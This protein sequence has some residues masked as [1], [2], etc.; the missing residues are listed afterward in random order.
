MGKFVDAA[1]LKGK[2]ALIGWTYKKVL[3]LA[4]PVQSTL[5]T[6][7]LIQVAKYH[8]HF[9]VWGL[10]V[11]FVWSLC[12]G[13]ALFAFG[14]IAACKVLNLLLTAV[15]WLVTGLFMLPLKSDSGVFGR[16]LVTMWNLL[17]ASVLGG[18]C[19]GLLV[20][21]F[22][23]LG[24]PVDL[25]NVACVYVVMSWSLMS[26]SRYCQSAARSIIAKSVLIYVDAA[27]LGFALSVAYVYVQG[28]I[29]DAC[30]FVPIILLV[31]FGVNTA[32]VRD[33]QDEFNVGGRWQKR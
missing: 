8:R 3:S 6:P 9:A 12:R 28:V 7:Y 10:P 19:V 33:Q 4:D 22:K 16:V 26:F 5:G 1:V 32:D 24:Q 18:F 23:V 25:F 27:L 29:Y 31:A 14:V 11:C 2:K 17:Y 30:F 15:L 13:E 21:T 20:L